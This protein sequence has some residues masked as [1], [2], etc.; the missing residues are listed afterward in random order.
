MSLPFVI[1]LVMSIVLG[2]LLAWCIHEAWD[3]ERSLEKPKSKRT[4]TP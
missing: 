1:V 4:R 3:I 2:V